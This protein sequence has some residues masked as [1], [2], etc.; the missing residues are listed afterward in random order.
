MCSYKAVAVNI[1]VNIW[2]NLWM[3]CEFDDIKFEYLCWLSMIHTLHSHEN[4][5]VPVFW[6]NDHVE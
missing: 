6:E 2:Q 3:Q 4:V 5:R 1:H